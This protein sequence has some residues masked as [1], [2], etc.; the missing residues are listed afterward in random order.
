ME[1]TSAE[2]I[3]QKTSAKIRFQT[4]ASLLGKEADFPYAI[5]K[6]EVLSCQAYGKPGC[7]WT[8]DVD[9]LIS[10]K[11]I[12]NLEKLLRDNGFESKKLTREE[13][14]ISLAFSHQVPLFHK[15]TPLSIVTVD[16]N[17]DIMWGE[18]SGKRIS[19]EEMLERRQMLSIYNIAVP[20]LQVQDSFFQ[21]CLHHYKDMNSLYHLCQG[22]TIKEQSFRDVAF[23]WQKQQ[24]ELDT[25]ALYE[26]IAAYH[27]EPYF[28]YVLYGANIV[29][30]NSGV[31]KALQRL[32]TPEG[33]QLLNCFGLNEKERKDWPIPF[34]ER[35]GSP[36]IGEILAGLLSKEDEEKVKQNIAIFGGV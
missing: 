13:Q 22:N 14:L 9:V 2:N 5:V 7:R 15:T 8:T 3:L 1:T 4:V 23:F 32:K 6:G 21:L 19:V 33:E 17:Y 30:P 20:V 29:C 18:W 31:Q 11:H 26:R 16:I 12:G 10:R 28:Y 34:E 35:I 36:K 25:E 24:K 27:L